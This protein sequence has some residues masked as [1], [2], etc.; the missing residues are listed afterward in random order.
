MPKLQR[1][2]EMSAGTG[3]VLQ[4]MGALERRRHS[5]LRA[6]EAPSEE[7]ALGLLYFGWLNSM[8]GYF[9]R[10]FIKSSLFYCFLEFC[11]ELCASTTSLLWQR[12]HAFLRECFQS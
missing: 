11:F 2:K 12:E 10:R 3:T 5:Q 7:Y 9:L 1:G 6:L 8:K 4:N